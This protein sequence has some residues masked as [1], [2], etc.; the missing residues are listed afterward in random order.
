[1]SDKKTINGMTVNDYQ[2]IVEAAVFIFPDGSTYWVSVSA[3]P[4]DQI[5]EKLQKISTAWKEAH[6]EFI[7]PKTSMAI[8]QMY[9]PLQT[10]NE[11]IAAN[12]IIEI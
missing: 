6:P 11:M 1:M 2:D 4:V 7:N 10:M 3:V 9:L 5:N 12:Q 8:A